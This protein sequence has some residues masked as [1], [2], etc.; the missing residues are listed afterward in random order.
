[1]TDAHRQA[2]AMLGGAGGPI[3]T[4]LGK[5]IISLIEPA[6]GR[7]HEYNRWYEDD[8]AYISAFALPWV[9]AG[10][11]WVAT[12]RLRELRTSASN[13]V[14]HPIDQ[15][16]YL[17]A[18][19]LIDGRYE[20]FL[21]FA[22]PLVTERLVPEGRMKPPRTH[23]FTNDHEYLGAVYRDPTGPRD[24]H[25]LSYPYAGLALQVIDAPSAEARPALERWLREEHL[26]SVLAGSPAAMTL[27]LAAT[28]PI[29]PKP[30][31]DWY[32][33]RLTLMTF[34]E[35]EPAGIWADLFAT[36]DA[37]IAASGLGEV[38]LAA[39]FL[40]TLPGTDRYVD[41]LR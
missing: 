17:A 10:K 11:R 4:K 19:W 41:E 21:A 7:E 16:C 8:H 13:A 34:L 29:R 22:R 5:A 6:L 2:Y 35:C 33:R 24:I 20:D 3:E 36:Q 14:A 40:P 23:V 28:P 15:G 26:P 1:M 32:E 27:V 39:P 9:F 30:G 18:Y 31:I 25:A 37:R 12:R 38:E